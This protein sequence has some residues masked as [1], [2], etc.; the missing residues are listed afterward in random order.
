MREKEKIRSKYDF[1]RCEISQY[2]LIWVSASFSRLWETWGYK[3]LPNGNLENV[4][5][6][7]ITKWVTL[8]IQRVTDQ[9][10]DWVRRTAGIAR[11]AIR[12]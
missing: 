10:T 3:I 4:L 1:D 9:P 11:V 8:Y 7:E 6:F 5:S 12:H 2:T